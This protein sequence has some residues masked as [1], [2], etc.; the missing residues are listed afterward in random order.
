MKKEKTETIKWSTIDYS[1]LQLYV[2]L[3]EKSEALDAARKALEEG[4]LSAKIIQTTTAA[5]PRKPADSLEDAS[6]GTVDVG[7][8][9]L[10]YLKRP[11]DIQN[12]TSN[13]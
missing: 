8:I 11:H 2:E 13:C 3:N 7:F 12:L 1:N 4:G 9:L 10:G 5:A 6:K